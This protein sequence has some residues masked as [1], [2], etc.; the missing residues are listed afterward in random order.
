MKFEFLK[1]KLEPL[2]LQYIRDAGWEEKEARD[3]RYSMNGKVVFFEKGNYFMNVVS[4]LDGTA[5]LRIIAKDPTLIDWMPDPE[6]FRITIKCPSKDHFDV[7][8][9]LL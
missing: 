3:N 4:L 5:I 1:E 9:S 6:Q 2:T 7:I 8:T